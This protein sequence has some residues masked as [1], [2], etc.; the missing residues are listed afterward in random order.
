MQFRESVIDLIGQTPLVRLGRLGQGLAPTI[1]AKLESANPGGSAKDRIA[2]RM[3]EAAEESGLLRE[4][5]TI[6]E[7][8]SGNTG[9]GLALVAQ[10]RATTAYSPVPT[11]FPPTRSRCCGPTAPRWSSARPRCRRIIRSPIAVW[12][13]GLPQETP[14][15]YRPDQY[16]NPGNPESH[17]YGTGPEIW[18]QTEG[19]VTVLVAGVGTG[20]TISGTGRYLKEVSGRQGARHRRRPGRLDLHRRL[21]R[22][23]TS[24]KAWASLRIRSRSTPR[25]R[26]DP[27]GRPTRSPIA[28]HPPAGP[29]GGHSHRRLGRDG[30]RGGA[31]LRAKLRAARRHGD[32]GARLRRAATCRRFSM[33]TGFS[34]TASKTRRAPARA[35]AIC[36]S[37]A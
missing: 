32:G 2:L 4:G 21:R 11:R 22:G 9:V 18:A 3:I 14:G 26:R 6:V 35:W 16:S 15:A 28:H 29:R 19:R 33:T 5:G 12:R 25:S 1:L 30:G 36:W 31:S 20:G 7:P 27:R 17:Y 8:T 37:T 23:P 34:S 24:W 10:R 13:N